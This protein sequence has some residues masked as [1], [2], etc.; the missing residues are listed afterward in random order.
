MTVEKYDLEKIKALLPQIINHKPGEEFQLDLNLDL[1]KIILG[2]LHIIQE[3]MSKNAL[4]AANMYQLLMG[5]EIQYGYD[6]E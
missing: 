4:R 6:P 2:R 5:N 3:E 1:S